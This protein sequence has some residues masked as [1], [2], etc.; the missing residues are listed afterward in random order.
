MDQLDPNRPSLEELERQHEA[1]LKAE[2]ILENERKL[3]ALI[4]RTRANARAHSQSTKIQNLPVITKV[5]LPKVKTGIKTRCK[6]DGG[7]HSAIK[8]YQNDTPACNEF[9][10]N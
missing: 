8:T 2:A 1:D 7:N 9:R 4:S 5:I 3:N 6:S 10:F